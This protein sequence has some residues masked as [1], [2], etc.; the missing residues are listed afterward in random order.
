MGQWSINYDEY[1]WLDKIFRNGVDVLKGNIEKIASRIKSSQVSSRKHPFMVNSLIDAV[2][3][4]IM[5]LVDAQLSELENQFPYIQMEA[6]ATTNISSKLDKMLDKTQD[7]LG[8]AW[9]KTITAPLD[10]PYE[11][12]VEYQQRMENFERAKKSLPIPDGISED[13]IRKAQ[14]IVKKE[15]MYYQ[16]QKRFGILGDRPKLTSGK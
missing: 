9:V 2:F 14:D 8:E 4:N 11:P 3:P 12:E 6:Q 15:S 13:D 10:S 7:L 16:K 1:E 5:D